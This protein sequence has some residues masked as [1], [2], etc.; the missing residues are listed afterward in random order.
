MALAN[1][2]APLHSAM[3]QANRLR[4]PATSV[5]SNHGDQINDESKRYQQGRILRQVIDHTARRDRIGAPVTITIDRVSKPRM[6]IAEAVVETLMDSNLEVK[7]IA[8]TS[9]ANPIYPEHPRGT[10]LNVTA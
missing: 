9:Q 1:I 10:L 2:H 6:S 7:P 8:Y 4:D 3:H 5:T